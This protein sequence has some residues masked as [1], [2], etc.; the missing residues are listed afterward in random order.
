MPAN[1]TPRRAEI[2]KREERRA[3]RQFCVTA[4]RKFCE[5]KLNDHSRQFCRAMCSAFTDVFWGACGRRGEDS[6][7]G[8]NT[9]IPEVCGRQEGKKSY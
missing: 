6:C 1:G 8:A 2:T 9:C 3:A 7:A 5:T 4:S